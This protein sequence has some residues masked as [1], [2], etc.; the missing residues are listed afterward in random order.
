MANE[1]IPAVTV[2]NATGRPDFFPDP[3][4]IIERVDVE[5]NIIIRMKRVVDPLTGKKSLK[6]IERINPEAVASK[7]TYKDKTM[8]QRIQDS[9]KIMAAEGIQTDDDVKTTL[10]KPQ[11]G[12]EN[13]VAEK[14]V[15]DK[16]ITKCECGHKAKNPRGLEVH[17]RN[18]KFVAPIIEG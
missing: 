1:P 14:P 7:S 13:P 17:K 6:V 11:K 12:V 10:T 9:E 16:P 8:E 3:D 2:V 15:I 18:C 4:E 5:N